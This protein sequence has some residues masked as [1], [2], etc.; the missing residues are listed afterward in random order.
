MIQRIQSVF[1][2]FV[3]AGMVIYLFLP[4]WEKLDPVTGTHVMFTPFLIS[5]TSNVNPEPVVAYFPYILCGIG[6][7]IVIIVGAIEIF[8]YKNRM[9]QIK[10]GLANSILMSLILFFSAWLALKAQKNFMPDIK[11][12]FKLGLFAPVVAMIFN[13][14]A[15][16]FI[17]KDEEKVRAA[18]RLR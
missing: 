3:I 4:F 13:S 16:R 12:D 18:D 1:L 2:L 15:N 5:Q 9:T 17:K 6:A 8:S 7:V 11:G 10:L 14:L